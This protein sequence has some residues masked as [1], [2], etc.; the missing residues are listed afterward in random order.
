M[1]PEYNCACACQFDL[2]YWLIFKKNLHIQKKLN[3]I[4]FKIDDLYIQWQLQ[5]ITLYICYER[6][7][8]MLILHKS[9]NIVKT[10]IYRSV[11]VSLKVGDQVHAKQ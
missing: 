9:L 6:Q 5:V 7:K 11:S 8:N 3:D 1:K 2:N 10:N 4:W